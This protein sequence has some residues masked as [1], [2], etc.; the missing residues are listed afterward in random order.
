[1]SLTKN[2]WHIRE[3]TV[4]ELESLLLKSFQ[5]VDKLGVFGNKKIMEYYE[6]NKASVAKFTRFDLLN[7]QHR[8]PRQLLQIPYD[9]M[10]RINRKILLRQNTSLIKEIKMNDYYIDAAKDDCFDLFYVAHK[11]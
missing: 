3:Y 8:A 5:S 10:N 7:L 9:I 11:M 6:K 2:P 1:M 4:N